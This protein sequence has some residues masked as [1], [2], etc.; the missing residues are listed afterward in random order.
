MRNRVSGRVPPHCISSANITTF[1]A[2]SANVTMGTGRRGS[3]IEACDSGSGA[4]VLTG[5]MIRDGARSRLFGERERLGV[6][7]AGREL[8]HGRHVGAGGE[9]V[10]DVR[11]E[12]L[13]LVDGSHRLHVPLLLFGH[14][15]GAL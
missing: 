10:Y 2:M 1:T 7:E 11:L 14:E 15:T 9:R 13:L 3:G 6:A 5:A 12:L 8:P 4:V